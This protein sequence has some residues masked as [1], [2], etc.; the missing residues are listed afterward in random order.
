[1]NLTLSR[2]HFDKDGIFGILTDEIGFTLALTLEHSYD[3]LPKL[4]NGE[5][6]CQ[7]GPHRLHGMTSDFETFEV[8][9]VPGHSGILF[10]WGN[11]NKDSDGCV[12]LGSSRTPLDLVGTPMIL[13]SRKA[14]AEFMSVLKGIDS[15]TLTVRN[16]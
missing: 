14:F 15:F 1:M 7:R 2:T 4:P 8:K 11:Y 3:L 12:L 13:N 5:Y 9:N 10:H 16:N 6:V